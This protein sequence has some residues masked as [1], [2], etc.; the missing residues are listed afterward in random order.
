MPVAPSA[1]AILATDDGAGMPAG[2]GWSAAGG[3]TGGQGRKALADQAA[4][5]DKRDEG[6]L[7]KKKNAQD[8]ATSLKF[9]SSNRN[10]DDSGQAGPDAETQ[11]S[12][13]AGEAPA[14]APLVA[15]TPSHAGKGQAAQP[16]LVECE[17]TSQAVHQRLFEKM[18]AEEQLSGKRLDYRRRGAA[19][20]GAPAAK[21]AAKAAP[22]KTAGAANGGGRRETGKLDADKGAQ[23]EGLAPS[24]PTGPAE[25]RARAAETRSFEVEA[26]AQQLGT[27]IDWLKARP[28]DFLSVTATPA[29]NQLGQQVDQV[30]AQDVKQEQANKDQLARTDAEDRRTL[31]Q[32]PGMGAGAMPAPRSPP[33]ATAAKAADRLLE[34]SRRQTLGKSQTDFAS[35][36]GGGTGSQQ[37]PQAAA[38]VTLGMSQEEVAVSQPPPTY[39]VRFILR[40]VASEPSAVGRALTDGAAQPAERAGS[41]EAKSAPAES[42][43]AKPKAADPAPTPAAAPPK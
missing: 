11:L 32:K 13:F 36:K 10:P 27:I 31:P 25:K 35:P 33:R 12:R 15:G 41:V 30:V 42:V 43:L 20:R 40:V 24:A 16:L 9:G 8:A 38:E 17:V 26:T 14:E 29:V 7:E 21:P 18:L 19:S 34:E 3:Q 2:A 37:K 23:V 4:L 6:R 39:R 1:P 28:E 22:D 5:R